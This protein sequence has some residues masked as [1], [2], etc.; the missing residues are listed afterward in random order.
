MRQKLDTISSNID[1]FQAIPIASMFRF[2]GTSMPNSQQVIA[3]VASVALVVSSMGLDG[4]N[5]KESQ[6]GQQAQAPTATFAMPTPDQ[7]YQLVAPI[8]LFP[9]NLVAIV[10]A[11]STYPDQITTAWQ[12]MQQN[13]GSRARS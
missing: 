7:L 3:I 13:G 9:D 12:W 4:C 2:G 1:R 6:A 5:K 8:A 11:S 10:L